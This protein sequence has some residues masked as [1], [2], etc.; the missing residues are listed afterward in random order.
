MA[1][2]LTPIAGPIV[3]RYA[4]SGDGVAIDCCPLSECADIDRSAEV[5]S[6][7]TAEPTERSGLPRGQEYFA[8]HEEHPT[9]RACGAF[10]PWRPPAACP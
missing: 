7:F 3:A 1:I 9:A 8:R 4:K 6:N 10:E 5:S 2:P